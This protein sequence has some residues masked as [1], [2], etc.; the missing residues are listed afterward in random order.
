[1]KKILILLVGHFELLPPFFQLPFETQWKSFKEN[2]KMMG[3]QHNFIISISLFLFRKV[4]AIKLI[5]SIIILNIP[6]L[7][8]IS[9]IIKHKICLLL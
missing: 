9:A 1:M 7:P 4:F 3:K 6:S 8:F 5:N 2:A